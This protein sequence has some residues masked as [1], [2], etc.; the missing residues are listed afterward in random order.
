MRNIHTPVYFKAFGQIKSIVVTTGFEGVFEKSSLFYPF[1]RQ[2]A[3]TSYQ[4]SS[5][6][7]LLL[8]V[9]LGGLVKAGMLEKCIG[10]FVWLAVMNIKEGNPRRG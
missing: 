2:L 10:L 5:I 9:N 3:D 4:E 1:F 8:S 7:C 6:F